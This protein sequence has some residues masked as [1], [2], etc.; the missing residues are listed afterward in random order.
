MN[1]SLLDATLSPPPP[2]NFVIPI[3]VWLLTLCAFAIGT[4]EFVI[5]GLLTQISDTLNIT[6]GKAGYLIIAF[7]MAVVLG[8]PPLTIFL[9]RFE[10]KRVLVLIMAVFAV[11]NLITAISSNFYVLLLSRVLAGLCQGPFYGIGAVV[12]TRIVH[13]DHA[14]KAVGQMFGGLTLA[15]VIG[16]PAGAWIGA[17]FGWA[18]TLYIVAAVGAVAVI[19]L[20][21]MLQ[22]IRPD[23]VP[24]SA[25]RQ[26]A[27]FRNPQLL[28]SLA[29]TTIAWA[30]FM[31]FYGYIAPVAQFLAGYS[32]TGTTIVLVIAGA[33][34]LI[35]NRIGGRG[36]DTNLSLTLV[37]W[38]LAMILSLVLIG[39]LVHSHWGFLIA[40]FLFG[41]ASFANVSPMQMRVMKYGTEAPELSATANISAFN[42]ANSIGGVLGGYVIDSAKFGAGSVPYAAIGASLL[43]LFLILSLEWRHVRAGNAASA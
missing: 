39:A 30:G 11:A 35:G 7:A 16:V 31:T 33:G 12:A 15:S 18:S 9:S 5:A 14:G 25:G 34:M 20:Q 1:A 37:I 6:E 19:G 27:A 8:G 42:L 22:P 13:S 41:I 38:P 43:G 17:Q 3:E 26:L 10:K 40:V 29:F 24:L 2:Q 4:S 23:A 28:A 36:A 32:I 21:T